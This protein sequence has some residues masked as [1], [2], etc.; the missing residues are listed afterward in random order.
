MV[1]QMHIIYLTSFDVH[2]GKGC[3]IYRVFTITFIKTNTLIMF[4]KTVGIYLK[5]LKFN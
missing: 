2:Q 4:D 5:R 3:F 1:I